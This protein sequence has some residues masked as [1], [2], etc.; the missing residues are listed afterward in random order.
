MWQRSGDHAQPRALTHCDPHRPMTDPLTIAPL[1][2]TLSPSH[3]A[4]RPVPLAFLRPLSD[5][6]PVSNT[7]MEH[8]RDLAVRLRRRRVQRCND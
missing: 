6:F 4:P 3:P 7:G 1:L 2:P 5:P 8:S